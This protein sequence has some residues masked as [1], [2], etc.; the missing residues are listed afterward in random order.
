[1]SQEPWAWN[2]ESPKESVQRSSQNTSHANHVVWSETLKCS[3]KSYVT[4]PLNQ[5]LF[6]W[7]SIHAGSHTWWNRINQ[8]LWAFRVSWSPGFMLGLLPRRGFCKQSTWPWNMIHLMPCRMPCRLYIHLAFAYSVGP[9]N[10][11]WGELGP[12]LPFPPICSWS[13]MVTGSQSCVWR[14]P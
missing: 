11:V 9:S 14:G 2:W 4:G 7:I 10:I 6:Q 12:A 3:V 5:M 8:W 13:V 1:M